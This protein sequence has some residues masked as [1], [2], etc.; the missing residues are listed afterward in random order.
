MSIH[1]SYT[2]ARANLAKLCDEVCTNQEIVIINRRN[3][4]NVAMISA[5]EL[6]SII[7]T[8]YLLRNKRQFYSS[9]I[10]LLKS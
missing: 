4:E 6:S 7:E 2:K 1:T 8:A 3:A 9:Q 10:S 5:S